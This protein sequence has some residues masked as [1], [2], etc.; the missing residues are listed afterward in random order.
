MV[1]NGRIKNILSFTAN[2]GVSFLAKNKHKRI[3]INPSEL[4]IIL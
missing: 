1:I 3:I 4:E 2:N